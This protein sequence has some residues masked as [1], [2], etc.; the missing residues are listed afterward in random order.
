MPYGTP[1]TDPR[2]RSTLDEKVGLPVVYEPLP[3]EAVKQKFS[4][5][6]N[7]DPHNVMILPRFPQEVKKKQSKGKKQSKKKREKVRQKKTSVMTGSRKRVEYLVVTF[8]HQWG[9]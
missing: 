1:I 4:W 7:I 8:Y 9:W 6:I 5:A 2:T 3:H